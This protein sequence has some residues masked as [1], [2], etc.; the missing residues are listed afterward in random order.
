MVL[1]ERFFGPFYQFLGNAGDATFM[2]QRAI[3]QN[4]A[5]ANNP[6]YHP[7]HV[8]FEQELQRQLRETLPMVARDWGAPTVT[9]PNLNALPSM[10]MDFD[11]EF[12]DQTKDYKP[13]IIRDPK[14]K[15]DLNYEMAQLAQMQ[16]RF[17]LIED[18]VQP[19]WGRYAIETLT[20]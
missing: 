1:A 19:A 11:P 4:I 20:K 15:V 10:K 8:E 3:A 9:Q 18:V 5:N 17:G 14:G 13:K 6:N 2:A 12:Y 16:F 7:V